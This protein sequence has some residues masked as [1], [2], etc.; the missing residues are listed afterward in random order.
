[1]LIGKCK[2][3]NISNY[4]DNNFLCDDCKLEFCDRCLDKFPIKSLT[5]SIWS[6]AMICPKCKKKELKE[7]A[8]EGREEK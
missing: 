4:L 3:C 2:K 8:K 1:M 7:I 6:T 5:V